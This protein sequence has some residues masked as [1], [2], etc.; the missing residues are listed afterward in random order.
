[1]FPMERNKTKNTS[2]TGSLHSGSDLSFPQVK[3]PKPMQACYSA[4][5]DNYLI[6]S[7]HYQC[8]H[9]QEEKTCE[10]SKAASWGERLFFIFCV[11]ACAY[12]GFYIIR[13]IFF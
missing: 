7:S 1:M 4:Y 11:C 13:G 8:W 5:D 3:S 12:L 6:N 2:Q 9:C 10:Y